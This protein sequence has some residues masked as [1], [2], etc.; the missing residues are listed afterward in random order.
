MARTVKNR[1]VLL[2]KKLEALGLEFFKSRFRYPLLVRVHFSC[3]F[4]GWRLTLA[5]CSGPFHRVLYI[6]VLTYICSLCYQ[7][8]PNQT[9]AYTVF[10]QKSRNEHR[11]KIKIPW[12]LLPITDQGPELCSQQLLP[13]LCHCSQ[14]PDFCPRCCICR[15]ITLPQFCWTS[16]LPKCLSVSV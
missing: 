11:I 13:G 15:T 10:V 9:P 2:S 3:F 16:L 6:Y 12:N 7:K 5:G 8:P 14:L 4:L 1:N